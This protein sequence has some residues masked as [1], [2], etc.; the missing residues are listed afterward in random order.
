[1][2]VKKRLQK[3]GFAPEKQK[4]E[5][6]IACM[7]KLCGLVDFEDTKDPGFKKA[8]DCAQGILVYL[9]GC[10]L[11]PIKFVLTRTYIGH[12]RVEEGWK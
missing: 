6:G 4:P 7:M 11:L 2:G 10:G 3:I 5:E 9:H 8:Y 12:H 1:M